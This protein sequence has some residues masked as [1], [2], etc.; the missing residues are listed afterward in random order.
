M[1]TALMRG[2]DC[3]QSLEWLGLA[4]ISSSRSLATESTDFRK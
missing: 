1:R 3:W 2:R 4:T